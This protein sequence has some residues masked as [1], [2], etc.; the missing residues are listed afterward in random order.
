[1]RLGEVTFAAPM[2]IIHY[3]EEHSYL[4]PAAFLRAIEAI[5]C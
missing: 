5:V 2:L 3:I 1:V 4:P